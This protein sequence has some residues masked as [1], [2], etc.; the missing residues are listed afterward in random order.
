MSLSR[1]A[2]VLNLISPCNLHPRTKELCWRLL[3]S[4]HL[5]KTAYSSKAVRRFRLFR[6]GMTAA[7]RAEGLISQWKFFLLILALFLSFFK[8]IHFLRVKLLQI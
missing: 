8:N 5:A 4:R 1:I 3:D 2:K 7:E 6:N